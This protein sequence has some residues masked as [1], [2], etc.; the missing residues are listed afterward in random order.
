[1]KFLVT[2]FTVL[3]VVFQ[4]S[5]AIDRWIVTQD[6]IPIY[7]STKM[8]VIDEYIKPN[9]V[10][11]AVSVLSETTNESI[12]G[13]TTFSITDPATIFQNFA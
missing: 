6:S 3:L 12:L 4:N 9:N 5:Y 11:F 10:V 7:T 8:N 1:M 2:I 13:V